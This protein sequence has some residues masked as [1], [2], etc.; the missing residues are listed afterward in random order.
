MKLLFTI[1]SVLL[2][3]LFSTPLMAQE[4]PQ[5]ET[6][7]ITAKLIEMEAE[8]GKMLVFPSPI[9]GPEGPVIKFVMFGVYETPEVVVDTVKET[10]YAKVTTIQFTEGRR[11]FGWFEVPEEEIV[12]IWINGWY[13]PWGD[14][15]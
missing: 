10:I 6:I 15:P 7:P 13:I 8:D 1:L 14:M 5:T 2:L 12:S 11:F 4:T 3:C 9:T